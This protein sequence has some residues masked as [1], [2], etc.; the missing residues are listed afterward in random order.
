VPAS[1][2]FWAAAR[3]GELLLQRCRGCGR[4]QHYPRVLCA[5]CWS[6]DLEWVRAGG[7]ARVWTYTVVHRPG[8][9]AWAEDVPYLLAIVELAEGPRLLTNLVRVDPAEAYV[10]MAVRAEFAPRGDTALVRFAPDV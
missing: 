5:H 6:E 8:H 1:E 10:G 9:P 7:R 4:H 3:R 2:P